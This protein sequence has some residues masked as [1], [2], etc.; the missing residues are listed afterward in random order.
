[1][2]AIVSVA[3]AVLLAAALSGAGQQSAEQ[4]YKSGL[5]EEEVGGDLQKA[6]AIFQEILRRF[7]DNLEVAAKA[8]LRIGFCY[9]KQGVKEAEKAFQKVIDNYPGETQAVRE[10]RES[11]ARLRQARPAGE[12]AST[13][14]TVRRLM[15]WSDLPVDGGISPDERYISI[16]DWQ[17]GD[18]AVKDIV[19]GQERRLTNKG[20]WD[21]AHPGYAFESVWSPDSQRVVY[22][23]VNANNA[24]ELHEVAIAD[25][26]PRT[27]RGEDKGVWLTLCE[28]SADGQSILAKGISEGMDLRL[29]SPA[30]G[31]TRII[32]SFPG[33]DF[34]LGN[35]SLAPDGR[36]IAYSRPASPNGQTS[37]IYLLTVADGREVPLVPHPAHDEFLSWLPG[38]RGILFVS[39][40]S[41]RF[42]AWTLPVEAGTPQG[43]PTMVKASTRPRSIPRPGGRWIR[44]LRSR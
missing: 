34:P 33:K 11:L 30:D 9:E 2:K 38:G 22:T 26:R 42:D 14:A 24:T 20:V 6:I 17:T 32:K 7:P 36:T 13:G 28:W 5:Y 10:A 4:L 39:D 35:A 1:M 43:S 15:Y 8:Q 19:T 12:K 31:A 21:D 27:V 40:R 41:G 16:T 44:R 25:P 23:W 29:I 18:L 37:D 3:I